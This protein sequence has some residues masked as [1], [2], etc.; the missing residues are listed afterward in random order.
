MS[1][2]YDLDQKRR[3]LTGVAEVFKGSG[4]R[5]EENEG[6]SRE[7]QQ[8]I[9]DGMENLTPFSELQERIM[10]HLNSRNAV[11]TIPRTVFDEI[12]EG[13]TQARPGREFKPEYRHAVEKFYDL[14]LTQSMML[15]SI[16]S[17]DQRAEENERATAQKVA[18]VLEP[19]PSVDRSRTFE[20]DVEPE[21]GDRGR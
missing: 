14:G 4:L 3:F 5:F 9:D 12:E 2:M 11:E 13:F 6:L 7:V 17:A 15:P 10:N 18:A 19:R 8:I 1:T 16:I 20:E 21:R